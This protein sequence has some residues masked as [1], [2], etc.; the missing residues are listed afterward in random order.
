MVKLESKKL[1]DFL[2]LANGMVILVLINLLAS[3][4]FFRIDLT[5]E[6]RFSIKEPTRKMLGELDDKVY[7]EVFLEFVLYPLIISFLGN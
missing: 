6:K 7:V 2:L 4:Y 3:H 5:E 1:G